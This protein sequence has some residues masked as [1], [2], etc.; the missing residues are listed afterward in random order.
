[1]LLHLLHW[2]SN[3]LGEKWICVTHRRRSF[4]WQVVNGRLSIYQRHDV[5]SWHL[6]IGVVWTKGVSLAN[7]HSTIQNNQNNTGRKKK[8]DTLLSPQTY[9][10]IR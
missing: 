7:R 4:H 2:L 3:V 10:N 6:G 8:E 1:M 5:G 9:I